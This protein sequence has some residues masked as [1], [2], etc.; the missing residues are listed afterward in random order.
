ML[1]AEATFKALIEGSSMEMYW[2]NIKKS[3]IWEELHKARNY[4]PVCGYCIIIFCN[5]P[6]ICYLI[7]YQADKPTL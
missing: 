2:E 3:W 4:R 7:K 6:Y 5:Q 1:A